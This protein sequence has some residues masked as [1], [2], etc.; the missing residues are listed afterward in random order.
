MLY[1]II[2]IETEEV[3]ETLEYFDE[4]I[5]FINEHPNKD[6]LYIRSVDGCDEPNDIDDDF[7]FDPYMGCYS[8]DC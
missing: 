1:E 6:D 7:G 5:D 3:V 8:Y 2:N 4:A